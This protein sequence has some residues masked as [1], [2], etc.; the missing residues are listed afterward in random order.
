VPF[1]DIDS[2]GAAISLPKRASRRLRSFFLA[3]PFAFL[4]FN[5]FL[6][7]W[8]RLTI[9]VVRLGTF[10]EKNLKVWKKEK[11]IIE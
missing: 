6:C 11:F 4:E 2:E 8:N 1:N 10:V 3:L 9:D 5:L 7:G